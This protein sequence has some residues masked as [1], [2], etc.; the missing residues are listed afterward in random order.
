VNAILTICPYRWNNTWVFDDPAVGLVR[1]PFVAG[2]PEMID[3]LVRDIPDAARGFRALFSTGP[4]PGS[5]AG[6]EWV[7][8]EADGN[9]YRWAERG[10]EGWLC[11]ALFKYFEKAPARLYVR[12]EALAR[13]EAV[14]SV[15][16]SEV[17]RLLGLLESGRIEEAKGL[18][19]AALG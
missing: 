14:I 2:M 8:E 6:L 11:P 3:L 13:E 12:A 10:M 19:R 1:E 5:Q 9:W 17:T 4:F 18:V 15:P 7:R 16:R